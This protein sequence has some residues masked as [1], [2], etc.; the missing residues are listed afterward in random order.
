[1]VVH[2]E[3]VGNAKRSWDADLP[4][5]SSQTLHR[6]IKRKK[7]LASKHLEFTME[8]DGNDTI[9]HIHAGMRTVGTFRVKGALHMAIPINL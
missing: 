8:V 3:N 4:L 1:M 9:G 6:E 5:L 2:F 7:A